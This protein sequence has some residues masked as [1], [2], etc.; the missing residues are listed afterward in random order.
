MINRIG[1]IYNRL[2]IID[3]NRKDKNGYYYNCKC[4][5]GNIKVVNY[6]KLQSNHSK[7]CGCL[8]KEKLMKRNIIHGHS[9]RNKI[10]SEYRSWHHLIERCTNSNT[11]NYKDY[12]GR[13]IT[14]C[15]EWLNSF[16]NFIS[17]MGLKPNKSYSIDRINND[18]GYYKD[19]CRW[20]S[21]IEQLNNTSRNKKV[22]NIVTGEEYSSIS[23]AAR[24]INMNITT[25]WEKLNNK[26]L[27]E[28]NLKLKE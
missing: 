14:V 5:C 15:D 20:A 27:N 3:I 23:V 2:T 25:L 11:K 18:L 16:E 9:F 13:G 12:G 28:T 10:T 26:Y 21:R 7:S 6:Y 8:G 1:E 4:E 17:D 19:N 22:T 24:F